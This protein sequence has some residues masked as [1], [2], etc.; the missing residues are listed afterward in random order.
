MTRT[1]AAEIVREARDELIEVIDKLKVVASATDDKFFET[2]IVDQ[3]TV[4]ATRDHDFLGGGAN[5]DDWIDKIESGNDA[6]A[7]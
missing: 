5:L 7:E 2:Y 3:L 4:L 6:A 1:E